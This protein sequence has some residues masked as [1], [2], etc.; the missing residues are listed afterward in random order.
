MCNSNASNGTPA[1]DTGG[2]RAFT[3][4]A[5]GLSVKAFASGTS[6]RT[7]A[8]ADSGSTD[9]CFSSREAFTE[10]HAFED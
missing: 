3:T 8:F 4:D 10:Y 7:V 6:G 9:H 5:E 1:P 2:D